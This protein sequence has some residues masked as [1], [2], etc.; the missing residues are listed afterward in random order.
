[1]AT[2]DNSCR[3]CGKSTDGLPIAFCSRRCV[4]HSNLDHET[5]VLF[6]NTVFQHTNGS[7]QDYKRNCAILPDWIRNDTNEHQ[8]L[9]TNAGYYVG[10]M[11]KDGMP[12][13]RY[14]PYMSEEHAT[15]MLNTRRWVFIARDTP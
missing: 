9:R 1:M 14:T 6:F 2:S 15:F 12:Y 11:T 13:A 4:Y 7:I 8:V 3:T 5:K 10:S